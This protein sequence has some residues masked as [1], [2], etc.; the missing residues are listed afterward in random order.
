MVNRPDALGEKGS[1]MV[2]Q[3]EADRGTYIGVSLVALSTLMYEILL[4]RI[5][6]V[7]LWYHYAFLAISVAMFGM[8]A[9]ALLVY[10]FPDRFTQERVKHWMTVSSLLLAVSVVAL[11]LLQLYIPLPDRGAGDVSSFTMGVMYIFSS[12]PFTFSGICIC[13]A[14]TRFPK[15]VSRVYAADLTGAALGCVLLVWLLKATD[16]ATAVMVVGFL[17][18]LGASLLTGEIGYGPLRKSALA[19]LIALGLLSVGHG[20]LSAM[21]GPSFY[22]PTKYGRPLY[23]KWNSFS[24]ITVHAASR[25]PIGWAMSPTYRSQTLLR[26]L[27]LRMDAFAGTVVTQFDGDTGKLDHL[28]Y[29]L[30]NLPHYLR[31]DAKVLVI[32]AGGGRD[33]LSALVFEQRSVL[34]VEMNEDILNMVNGV[35]GDF[36]GHLDRHPK[37]RFVNDEARSFIA[38]STEQFDIIQV[39]LIDTFAATAAGAFALTENSLYTVEAWKIFLEHLSPRGLLTFS[40]GYTPEKPGELYRLI[41][42]ASAALAQLGVERPPDHIA[43]VKHLTAPYCSII[44][45]RNPFSEQ[46]LEQLDSL[47]AE[48]M[49]SLLLTPRMAAEPNLARLAAGKGKVA[50]VEGQLIDCSPPTDDRPFF[51][52][53]IPLRK[54]LGKPG[55]GTDPYLRVYK[56]LISLLVIVVV[57]TGLCLIL[58]LLLKSRRATLAGAVPLLIFFGAIG[59]GF[60]LVEVSQL[61]RLII[62]LGHPTYSLTVVLFTLLLASGLGS[63]ATQVAG[64]NLKT[65]G[66][67]AL[68]ILEIVLVLFGLTVPDLVAHF[69]AATTATRIAIAGAA[70]APIGFFM[71]M[72]FPLG[73]RLA[74]GRSEG[75][76]AWLWGVNG[77]TSVL[78]SVFA[79]VIALAVGISAAFWTGVLFYTTALTAFAWAAWRK[80]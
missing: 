6:S 42:L 34:A 16:G 10:L 79:V 64:D 31:P 72:P 45:S 20:A 57:L 28:K 21:G 23:E 12:L 61:Q 4:T 44:V 47:V 7:R 26:Q 13:L 46:D 51:F 19:I 65:R 5:F 2:P 77:A 71:G 37:V 15:Q 56:T 58:P 25:R 41:S 27:W 48:Q 55:W 3:L 63:F 29:D 78:A 73:M 76:T 17:A 22:V 66:V 36:T 80:R 69:Q 52:N 1:V 50:Q 67:A 11:L 40:R 33:V 70:L 32:G 14:V 75:L 74:F 62:F 18:A 9:G 53:M 60:M 8:T 38:R 59:F 30:V 49:H 43:A 35:F 54:A 24:Y 68:L 39:S